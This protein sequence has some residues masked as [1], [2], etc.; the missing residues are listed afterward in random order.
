VVLVVAAV[1]AD[2]QVV[3]AADAADME[4][5]A[6]AVVVETDLAPVV[7]SMMVSGRTSTRAFNLV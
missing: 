7:V 4:V 1:A 5:A 2:T 6:D 3:V